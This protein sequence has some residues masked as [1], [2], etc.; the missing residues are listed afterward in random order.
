MRQTVRSMARVTPETP[1]IVAA[2]EAI[3]F[4]TVLNLVR[5]L[6]AYGFLKILIGVAPSTTGF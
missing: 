4:D 5:D 1:L 3:D 2:N 6:E